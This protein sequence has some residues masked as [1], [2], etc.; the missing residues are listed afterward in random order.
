MRL[1]LFC[2]IWVTCVCQWGRAAGSPFLS[3]A[4]LA[5][6]PDGRWLV[7]ACATGNQLV[8]L[9][10]TNGSLSME[11]AAGNVRTNQALPRQAGLATGEPK[12][13]LPTAD[14][15]ICATPSE[16][17]VQGFKARISERVGKESL[18]SPRPSPPGEGE[19][20][21]AFSRGDAPG[22]RE[23]A[24]GE[25]TRPTGATAV[26]PGSRLASVSLP[27]PPTGLAVSPDGT[28]LYV[29]CAA[30]ESKVCI[31]DLKKRKVTGTLAAGHTA[32]APVLAQD[33]QTLYVCNEFDNDVNVID[34][35]SRKTVAR[36]P[37]Q[38]EPVAA[39]ITRDGRFLLVANHLPAGRADVEMVTSVVSVIDLAA[40]KV[41]KEL[42]LPNGSGNLKDIKVSPDGRYAAVSH[43]VASFSRAT[44]QVRLGWMNANALTVIDVGRMEV[45]FSFLL[46]EPRRGAGNPWGVA[47]SG[48]G[49]TLAVAHAGTHEISL[50]NF[51]MLLTNRPSQDATYSSAKPFKS[52]Q[53]LPN[54]VLTSIS[55]YEG[56]DPGLP[57]LTGARV[58]VKLPEGDLGPR[59]LFSVGRQLYAANY[60]SDTLTVMD[61]RRPSRRVLRW[62]RAGRWMPCGRGSFISTT[63]RFASRAGRAARVAIRATRGWMVLTG[64]C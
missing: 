44:T 42:A 41:V 8:C 43:I 2:L 3:P 6:T 27:L 16:T 22:S 58:R 12:P 47:W 9:E 15:A 49:N 30:P 5:A 14:L 13:G 17:A 51:P 24:P 56:L 18:P 32:M 62:G 55:H 1:K 37:V 26:P 63:P 48:D 23:G 33:G 29:T 35:A 53:A 64:I 7:A 34:L 36:I 20:V 38:R 54:P 39:D 59:A 25:G 57:F 50:I 28:T 21:P 40:R 19:G 46:D 4:A 11:R 52:A 45:A 60:F 10:V 31:V 61:W